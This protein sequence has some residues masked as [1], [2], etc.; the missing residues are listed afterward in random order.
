MARGN[1]EQILLY[2]R[3]CWIVNLHVFYLIFVVYL[4]HFHA[5]SSW[6]AASS[7]FS[8]TTPANRPG[9]DHSADQQCVIEVVV[10]HVET[11]ARH[12][13]RQQHV[14]AKLRGG[15]GVKEWGQR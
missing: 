3:F 1:S 9:T 6:C 14:E 7:R 5:C 13:T 10:Q 12:R 2:F 8:H 4:S 11:G 15:A